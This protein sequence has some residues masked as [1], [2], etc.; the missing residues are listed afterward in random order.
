M[1]LDFREAL[2]SKEN[3]LVRFMH[4][5]AHFERLATSPCAMV[6]FSVFL[7]HPTSI[8]TSSFPSSRAET[9]LTA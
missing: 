6:Q 3:M 1:D 2:A 7:H 8:P 5:A 4:G 9:L